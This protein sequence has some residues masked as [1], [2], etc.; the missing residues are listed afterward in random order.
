MHD[1]MRDEDQLQRLVRERAN[2]PRE[3]RQMRR[4]LQRAEQRRA[5]MQRLV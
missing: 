3:L 5:R 4:N 1:G 2:R